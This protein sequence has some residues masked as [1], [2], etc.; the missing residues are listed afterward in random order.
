[1]MASLVFWRGKGSSRK[2]LVL[3]DINK[4]LT[5]W[6]GDLIIYPCTANVV[7]DVGI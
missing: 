7:F 5:D 3:F 1:M 6:T 2:K 4:F